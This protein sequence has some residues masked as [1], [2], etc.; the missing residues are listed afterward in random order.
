MVDDDGGC[1]WHG[2]GRSPATRGGSQRGGRRPLTESLVPYIRGRGLWL[3]INRVHSQNVTYKY[4]ASC[5]P[6][7]SLTPSV[8]LNSL[9][10]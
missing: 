1:G 10:E 8:S 5:S 4:E 2:E 3:T 9:R 6:R 7:L